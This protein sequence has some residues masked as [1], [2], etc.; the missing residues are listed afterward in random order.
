MYVHTRIINPIHNHVGHLQL[1]L[2]F[3]YPNLELMLSFQFQVYSDF[4]RL[5][6]DDHNDTFEVKK[7]IKTIYKDLFLKPLFGVSNETILNF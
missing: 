5:S 4:V 6:L 1:Q 7:V 2:N 3:T